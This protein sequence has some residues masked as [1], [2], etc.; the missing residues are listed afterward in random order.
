MPCEHYKDAL[1]EVAASGAPPQGELRAHLAACSSCREAFAQEQS[2]FAA[3]DSGLHATANAEVP[4]SLLPRVRAM[5]DEAAAPRFR[6]MP[7]AIFAS[8]CAV[9]V[10][11]LFLVA[12]PAHR[13]PENIAKQR[14]VAAPG[15]VG[16]AINVNPE[17]PSNDIPSVFAANRHSQAARNSTDLHA[18]AS[19]S[20]EVLVPPNERDA[21]AQLIAALNERNSVAAAL[22]AHPPEKEGALVS[23]DPLQI[24]DIEIKPLEG[25]EAETSDGAGEKL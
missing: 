22:L 18:A 5:L 19:S 21:F 24:P 2:L 11:L 10:L 16:S 15:P 12:R 23:A 13:A 20:P 6:W 25:T 8:A 14:P 17:G 9:L 1:I 7:S 3:I 4:P